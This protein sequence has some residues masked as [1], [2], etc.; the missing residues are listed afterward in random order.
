M[1]AYSLND[2]GKID[3]DKLQVS[4]TVA[5]ESEILDDLTNVD[6]LVSINTRTILVITVLG[7]LLIIL[8]LALCLCRAKEVE[9]NLK[10]A[11]LKEH[12]LVTQT[13]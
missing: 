4:V 12:E 13:T 6:K 10:K 3:L 1:V 9:N 2:I 11:A 5:G 8:V 7:L